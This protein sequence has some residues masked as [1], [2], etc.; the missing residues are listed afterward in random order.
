MVGEE[1]VNATSEV[2]N[3]VLPA[4]LDRLS[5]LVK[6]FGAVGIALLVYIIYKLVV[7]FYGWKHRKR[8]INIEQKV[9]EIDKK[10]DRLLTKTVKKEKKKK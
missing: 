2:I 10:L 4:V 7:A 1:V 6:I 9:E 3:D 8:V 5:P